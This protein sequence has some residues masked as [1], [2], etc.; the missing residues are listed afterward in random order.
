LR[1]PPSFKEIFKAI[2]EILISRAE[3]MRDIKKLTME[4][5]NKTHPI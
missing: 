5:A 2:V 3:I 4:N 1:S